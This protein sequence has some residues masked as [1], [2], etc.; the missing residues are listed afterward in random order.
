MDKDDS[1]SKTKP[2]KDLEILDLKE[3]ADLLKVSTRTVHVYMKLGLPYV[4]IVPKGKL[5]FEKDRVI[6]WWQKYSHPYEKLIRRR[7]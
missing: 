5:T 7:R 2:K 6:H 3:C 4:Q 1:Y